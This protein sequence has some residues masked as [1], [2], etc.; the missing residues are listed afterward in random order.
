[1]DVQHSPVGWGLE[2]MKQK[3][4]QKPRELPKR[5]ETP[6]LAATVLT[7]WA[8]LTGIL[9]FG[10]FWVMQGAGAYP[11]IPAA[12]AVHWWVFFPAAVVGGIIEMVILTLLDVWGPYLSMGY[13]KN[14][15]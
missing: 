6:V 3:E 14:Y 5:M 9:S 2:G 13:R 12:L 15:D 11:S 8:V 1:M 4:P 10:T 7:I